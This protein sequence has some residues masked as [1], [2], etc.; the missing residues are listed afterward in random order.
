[1]YVWCNEY[2]SMTD[3]IGSLKEIDSMI[4][5]KVIIMSKKYNKTDQKTKEIINDQIKIKEYKILKWNEWK[6]LL[7]EYCNENERIPTQKTTY[8]NIGHFL[9]DCKKK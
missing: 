3:I 9:R 6:E 2:E 8:K 5:Q 7:F 4:I 1:M